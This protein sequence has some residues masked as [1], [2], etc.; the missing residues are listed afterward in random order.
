MSFL[1]VFKRRNIMTNWVDIHEDFAKKPPW[2]NKTRQQF[3]ECQG[4]IYQEAEEWIRAGFKPDDLYS[5][6]QW[7]DKKF[8]PSVTK[9]WVV[10]G[11]KLNEAEK[12][13]QWK[14]QG[15]T[16]EQA[17]SWI[18]VGLKPQEVNLVLYL[19]QNNYQPSQL[20]NSFQKIRKEFYLNYSSDQICLNENCY[21]GDDLEQHFSQL[22]ETQVKEEQIEISKWDNI[23]TSLEEEEDFIRLS[24]GGYWDKK[25][26]T[27]QNNKL[28]SDKKQIT[29]Q[30]RRRN[31]YSQLN[32]GKNNSESLQVESQTVQFKEKNNLLNR[33]FVG[34]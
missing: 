23:K 10:A 27:L 14:E 22:Q 8:D 15:F 18:E 7:K 9:K 1:S 3:W 30:T 2:S 19:K 21:L 25:I 13:R 33:K 17:K 32:K 28:P 6:C 11:F 20:F 12:A 29:L 24:D 34:D 4:F 26:Q 5:V 31:Y 16:P